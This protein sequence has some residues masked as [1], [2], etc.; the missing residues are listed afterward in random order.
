M[1]VFGWD[2]WVLNPM[3]SVL[4]RRGGDTDTWRGTCDDR[5]RD[6][7][8]DSISQGRSEAAGRQERCLGYSPSE[9]PELG[10]NNFCVLSHQMYGHVYDSPRKLTEILNPN[11]QEDQ[12]SSRHPSHTRR[13]RRVTR[14]CK[15]TRPRGRLSHREAEGRQKQ[16]RVLAF[17]GPWLGPPTGLG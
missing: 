12:S 13:P 5:G 16:N 11:S 7:R 6:S 4:V 9:R 2:H 10:E 1:Q 15:E 8:N 14:V 3:T 17:R